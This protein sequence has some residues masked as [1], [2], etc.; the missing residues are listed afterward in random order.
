MP[1]PSVINDLLSAITD[2]RIFGERRK[3]RRASRETLVEMI[4][5]LLGGRGE[6]SATEKAGDFLRAYRD[7][8][9][10]GRTFVFRTLAHDYGP[11][12]ETLK[13]AAEAYI[14]APGEAAAKAL[15]KA[16]EPR[17][18]ELFRRLNNITGGTQALVALRLE[19]MERIAH[20][21]D[22]WVV[23]D[24]LKR[25]FNAWFNRGF[26][27]LREIDW[28]TSAAILEKII[29]YEAV[30]AINGWDDL[31]RR[32]DVPDRRLFGFFHP[33][34][35]DEPLI[36]VEVALSGAIP[37]AIGPV[38]AED[39]TPIDPRAATTATFYSISN[40]QDGLRGIS[41]GS[42]LIK[43]VAG[44][45]AR[46]LP[47]LKTFVTLSPVPG[48]AKWLREEAARPT[49]AVDTPTRDLLER[50]DHDP[51][52]LTD[53]ALAKAAEVALMPL[54]AHYLTVA[55]D[56]KG[57]VIDPVARFHL[58]NGAR[59]EQIDF[60]AD[61]S[62]RGIKN[63]FGMMVNYRYVLADV[64]KNHEAFV[65]DGKVIATPAITKLARTVKVAERPPS[66]APRQLAP[67]KKSEPV[68][69]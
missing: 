59:L 4:E 57:R 54:A 65:G 25:L 18:V 20:H 10:A 12:A 7:L 28:Q 8:D 24:D 66:D 22:L 64:E 47:N 44:D 35:G 62:E 48:F 46:E 55:R 41:F 39:R 14:A 23:D 58:G 40:C 63:A 17:R 42:F 34:L 33:R 21:P 15:Q 11:H 5:A 9:Y 32:I 26:L 6:A 61:P 38:L 19:L 43:Q 2:N 52:F 69:G 16:A 27:D 60:N 29:R 37:T 51:A 56:A 49:S 53:P 36:F 50:L 68:E 30:H 31:R 45:L 13:A 3:P 67:P 1:Q